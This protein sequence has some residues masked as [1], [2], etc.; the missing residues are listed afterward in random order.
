VTLDVQ[1]DFEAAR[2]A[3]DTHFA[4]FQGSRAR[5]EVRQ[6]AEE[7]YRPELY[8]IP[9]PGNETSVRAAVQRRVDTLRKT[10]PGIVAVDKGRETHVQIP[11]GHRTGHEGH[12]AE[13]TRAFL[14]YLRKEEPLPAW[15][16]PNMLAKYFVTTG[17]VA[18]SRA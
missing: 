13:V 3:G 1:W 15:E 4:G 5:I 2:G 17:G 11:D 14:R 12:F 6:G 18:L 10:Y 16:K 8:A 7:K 9:A